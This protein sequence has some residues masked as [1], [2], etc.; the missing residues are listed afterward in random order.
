MLVI[1]TKAGASDYEYIDVSGHVKSD[2][3]SNYVASHVGLAAGQETIVVAS[4]AAY[5]VVTV[6]WTEK[7][8]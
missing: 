8:E 5:W 4:G 7:I 3:A 6:M 1:S 2:R